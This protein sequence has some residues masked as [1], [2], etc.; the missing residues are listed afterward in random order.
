MAV[1]TGGWEPVR[2]SVSGPGSVSADGLFTAG[3]SSG[4]ALVTVALVRN[5]SISATSTISVGAGVNVSVN[6]LG[7]KIVVPRSRIKL[8]ATVTGSSNTAVTWAVPSGSVAGTI[9]ADGT[10]TAPTAAGSFLVTARSAA[11]PRKTAN[12]TVTVAS[13]ARVL[14]NMSSGGSFTLNLRPDKAPGHVANF[15]SLVNEGFYDGIKFHRREDLDLSNA[16]PDFI[17]QGGDP[18]TKTLPLSDPSIG[19]GGPG[20][21]I[22]FET[23]DLKHDQYALAMARSSGLDTAGSQFYLCQD[24]VH[25]LD[26]NYV[27]FGSVASGFTDVDALRVGDTISSMTTIP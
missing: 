12:F 23:N 19:S 16:I 11:D 5:P 22:P 2:W 26:G 27:V 13:N 6:S 4:T 17:V 14:V 1:P 21:A 20:Y 8:T 3:T 10:Y 9:S 24:A 18:L 15:V 7:G 25:F